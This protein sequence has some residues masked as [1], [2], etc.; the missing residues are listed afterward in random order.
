MFYPIFFVET[1]TDEIKKHQGL[2]MNKL[3]SSDYSGSLTSRRDFGS[4]TS[5]LSVQSRYTAGLGEN[6]KITDI[7]NR[8]LT[9]TDS[10][11]VSHL[12]VTKSYRGEPARFNPEN[13]NTGY[14]RTGGFSKT[15]QSVQSFGTKVFSRIVSGFS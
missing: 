10:K 11:P 12:T 3:R 7:T 5:I 8:Y 14:S 4:N 2:K 9:E 6:S 1:K 15:L 13:G